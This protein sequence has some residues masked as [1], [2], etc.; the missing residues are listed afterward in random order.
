MSS[1]VTITRLDANNYL[2]WK[3]R[4]KGLLMRE[5]VWSIVEEGLPE[6][7]TTSQKRDDEAATGIICLY[8][9][10]QYVD[11]VMGCGSAKAAWEKLRTL[12]EGK[13][14]MRKVQLRRQLQGLKM[15]RGEQ[16][17]SYFARARQLRDELKAVGA[18]VAEDEVVN[19]A[20]AGLP[21]SFKAAS[22]VLQLGWEELELDVVM[23]K[24]K[25]FEESYE[26][27][28]V[29]ELKST[30]LMAKRGRFK[31]DQRRCYNCGKIG[32]I[33]RHCRESRET[34]AAYGAIVL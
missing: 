24:L 18:D 6:R 13:S 12:F 22:T 16:L 34:G 28:D 5:K 26:T 32:H 29:E 33:A 11:V 10:D 27:I 15:T 2:V 23:A 8:V 21:E 17:P 7:P 25:P 9:T 31:T 30:A 1:T 14:S 4:V 20:L 3:Q 19:I